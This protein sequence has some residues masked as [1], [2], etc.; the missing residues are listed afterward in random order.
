VVIATKLRHPMRP[1]H[2]GR[3]LSRK[4]I[5][6]EVDHS[7]QRLGTDYI[8]LYQLHR[9]DHATPIE[10]TLE[11]WTRSGRSPTATA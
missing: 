8:D 2:N 11:A 7:L 9:N 5:M 4:A 3:G 1:G 6:T 10:E